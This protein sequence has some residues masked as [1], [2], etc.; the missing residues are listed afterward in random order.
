MIRT[1]ILSVILLISAQ[2]GEYVIKK[3]PYSVHETMQKFKTLVEKKGFTVFAHIDHSKNAKS[4]KLHMPANE[5]L[6]F[7]N[8]KGG[9]L[10][11]QKDPHMGIELPLKVLVYEKGKQ[12]Y[13][14]YKKP[15]AWVKEHKALLNHKLIK[16]ITLGLDKLTNAV[17]K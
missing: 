16:K 7:G 14:S 15:M 10:L 8:P 13:I 6:I 17:I 4:V 2:A 3:S 12:S 1:V 9:T 11:M 5:L